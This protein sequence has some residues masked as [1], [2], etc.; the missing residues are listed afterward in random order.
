M[1]ILTGHRPTS[2]WRNWLASLAA[3]DRKHAL[4]GQ[5]LY[6]LGRRHVMAL[7]EEELIQH[8]QKEEFYLGCR[9][10]ESKINLESI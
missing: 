7:L 3:R 6:K 1:R 8:G 9:S 10:I 2:I 4:A 5:Q